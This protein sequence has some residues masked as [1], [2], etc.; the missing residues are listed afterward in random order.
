[1]ILHA[2][3]FFFYV[4]FPESWIEFLINKKRVQILKVIAKKGHYKNRMQIAEQLEQL[5]DIGK[6]ELLPI[7]INDSIEFIFEKTT[8]VSETLFLKKDLKAKI[9]ERKIYW[10]NKKN[11]EEKQKGITSENL[12]NT[13]NFK[14]KFGSGESLKNAKEML[15]KPMNT[16]K[17]F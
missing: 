8:V 2:L 11:A 6:L 17:W 10:L 12:K 5:N 1:M 14:R 15:K 3:Y 13:S 7:L 9:E 4:K 16:G